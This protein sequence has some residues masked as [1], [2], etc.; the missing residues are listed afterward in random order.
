MA[1]AVEEDAEE[2]R[3]PHLR[4][5]PIECSRSLSSRRFFF[6]ELSEKRENETENNHNSRTIEK[7]KDDKSPSARTL[8]ALFSFFFSF[9]REKRSTCAPAT[10]FTA[11]RV[12][13]GKKK[14]RK[15]RRNVNRYVDDDVDGDD[16]DVKKKTTIGRK[17]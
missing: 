11:E 4:P 12:K 16:S 14:E 7:K 1:E 10:A 8:F 15:K 9:V 13:G 6:L 3:P 5:S 17:K 2:A